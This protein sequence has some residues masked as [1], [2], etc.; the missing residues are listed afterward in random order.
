LLGAACDGSAPQPDEDEDAPVLAVRTAALAEGR[1]IQ[2]VPSAGLTSY[3]DGT[4]LTVDPRGTVR[5]IEWQY[6]A[7]SKSTFSWLEFVIASC[8]IPVRSLYGDPSG[9]TTRRFAAGQDAGMFLTQPSGFSIPDA[10][11]V[12]GMKFDSPFNEWVTPYSNRPWVSQALLLCAGQKALEL[13]QALSSRYVVAYTP[14]VPTK[15]KWVFVGDSDQG[16]PSSWRK[17]EAMLGG[18]ARTKWFKLPAWDPTK[19]KTLFEIPAPNAEQAATWSL[20][21]LDLF[22]ESALVGAAGLD[23]YRTASPSDDLTQWVGELPDAKRLSLREVVIGH[24][25]DALTGMEDASQRAQLYVAAAT[26][27][28]TETTRDPIKDWRGRFGSRLE[29]ARVF[30]AVDPTLFETRGLIPLYRLTSNGVGNPVVVRSAITTNIEEFSAQLQKLGDSLANQ[31]VLGYVYPPYLPRPEGT[32]VLIRRTVGSFS[33]TAPASLNSGRPCV[34]TPTPT[35]P[36]A[37]NAAEQEAWS[38]AE[39]PV[40]EG[41]VPY[42]SPSPSGGTTDTLPTLGLTFSGSGTSGNNAYK[43]TVSTA[44]NKN[45]TTAPIPALFGKIVRPDEGTENFNVENPNLRGGYPVVTK[46]SVSN[47]DRIA[48]NT[49]RRLRVSP[50][51]CDATTGLCAGAV[52]ESNTL[53]LEMCKAEKATHPNLSCNSVKDYYEL[54]HF[55]AAQLNIA[56]TRVAQ[57]AAALGHVIKVDPETS[58]DGGNIKLVNGTRKDLRAVEPAYL[59][60]RTDGYARFQNNGGSSAAAIPSTLD[61]EFARRGMYQAALYVRQALV[62]TDTV[63]LP[64]VVE[65]Q[66]KLKD[67]VD[68]LNTG[69]VRV[70]M[71]PGTAKVGSVNTAVIALDVRVLESNPTK[72]KYQ[73][74][75]GEDGLECALRGAISGLTCNLS[76]FLIAEHVFDTSSAVEVQLTGAQIASA[77]L[78]NPASTRNRVYLVKNVGA[79]GVAMAGFTLPKSI[80][81][82]GEDWRRLPLLSSAVAQAYTDTLAADPND[83]YRS[84]KFCNGLIEYDMRVKVGKGDDGRPSLAHALENARTAATRADQLATDVV[85]QGLEMDARAER[86]ADDLQDLCGVESDLVN[87]NVGEKTDDQSD[88]LSTPPDTSGLDACM[89]G[90]D[91]LTWVSVGTS[92]HC[93]WRLPGKEPCSCA[94]DSTCEAWL[95]TLKSDSTTKIFAQCPLSPVLVNGVENLTGPL[96]VGADLDDDSESNTRTQAELD[97]GCATYYGRFGSSAG[98]VTASAAKFP[99]TMQAMALTPAGNKVDQGPLG[100][101]VSEVVQNPVKPE[102]WDRAATRCELLAAL[103]KGD[104]K[105]LSEGDMRRSFQ[106]LDYDKVRDVAASIGLTIDEFGR[107][108]LT[109]QGEPWLRVGSMDPRPFANPGSRADRRTW[110]NVAEPWPVSRL[111]WKLCQTEKARTELLYCNGLNFQPWQPANNW[112]PTK[113]DNT[114][115][116]KLPKPG[117]MREALRIE[118]ALETLQHLTG[119]T[120]PRDSWEWTSDAVNFGLHKE[121][122]AVNDQVYRD[123]T[124]VNN[125]GFDPRFFAFPCSGTEDNPVCP[126]YADILYGARDDARYFATDILTQ[127]PIPPAES[128]NLI[129]DKSYEDLVQPYNWIGAAAFQAV[130]D[131]AIIDEAF[132]A[133]EFLAT[134]DLWD[135][136]KDPNHRGAHTAIEWT[137]HPPK[138]RSR[139]QKFKDAMKDFTGITGFNASILFPIPRGA[140]IA[141]TNPFLP[142]GDPNGIALDTLKRWQD[143]RGN[144]TVEEWPVTR[145]GA[146]DAFSLVCMAMDEKDGLLPLDQV[147]GVKSVDDLTKCQ[148]YFPTGGKIPTLRD[149]A[150]AAD[151]IASQVAKQVD[152]MYVPHVPNALL[153]TIKANGEELVQVLPTFAGEY[154][155]AVATLNGDIEIYRSST[156]A[157][158]RALNDLGYHVR[159]LERAMETLKNELEINEIDFFKEAAQQATNCAV[160]AASA[161]GLDPAKAAGGAA[162]AT[163]TCTNMV[164]QILASEEIKNLRAENI[165]NKELQEIDDF[166]SKI[167]GVFA[168]LEEQMVATRQAHSRIHGTIA[169]MDGIRAKAQRAKARATLAWDLGNGRVNAVN[170]VMR[171]RMNTTLFRYDEAWRQAVRYGFIARKSVEQTYGEEL[172]TMTHNMS[173]FGKSGAGQ[174][175]FEWAD[176]ICYKRGLDY[177]RIRRGQSNSGTDEDGDGKKDGESAAESVE[178]YAESYISDYVTKLEDFVESYNVDFPYTEGSDTVVVSLRDELKGVRRLDC[179]VEGPNYLFN[180]EA[181][182]GGLGM[183]VCPQDGTPCATINVTPEHEAALACTTVDCDPW[184]QGIKAAKIAPVLDSYPSDETFNVP[185]SVVEQDVYVEAGDYTVSFYEKCIPTPSPVNP[186]FVAPSAVR[187]RYVDPTVNGI[188]PAAKFAVLNPDAGNANLEGCSCAKQNKCLADEIVMRTNSKGGT[189]T[190]VRRHGLL[191]FSRPGAASIGFEIAAKNQANKKTLPYAIVSAPQLEPGFSFTRYFPTGLDGF[192]NVG[193]CEDSD[194]MNFRGLWTQNCEHYCP[195]GYGIDCQQ[196][197]PKELLPE[198]C[199][200]ELVFSISQEDI[201]RGK[202]ITEAGFAKGNFNYRIDT[203]GVN[204]VGTGVKNCASSD[205]ASACNAGQFLQY[206]VDQVGTFRT[207]NY[208]GDLV[209]APLF[210]GK[211]QMAKG[212]AAER[213]LTNPISSGDESLMSAYWRTELNERPLDGDYKIRV[214]KTEGL[215][216]QHLEDVQLVLKYQYWTRTQQQ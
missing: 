148:S 86:A 201:E 103:Y 98:A 100:L 74:I 153:P 72:G 20:L 214:Y 180:T 50:V 165:D 213:Y 73:L 107:Y 175:P 135:V 14:D 45:G 212:L 155:E 146:F 21:A 169:K 4:P 71:K 3:E 129:L 51:A 18:M 182:E 36:R 210:P 134:S 87:L 24:L 6:A 202:L 183:W 102:G 25:S 188:T 68:S 151:C 198:A 196:R 101:P 203:L 166:R 41:Y 69:Y 133:D 131:D 31:V 8:D 61:L 177:E 65:T 216:W 64:S 115:A 11:V 130:H 121:Y 185:A 75:L 17:H 37:C 5:G 104:Y 197:I 132:D 81:A 26:S 70:T 191:H 152:E 186:K 44:Q 83:S 116:D 80:P 136:L 161:S 171:A 28:D 29:A 49:L 164:V 89:A 63:S 140:V 122:S 209:G 174:A 22:R 142:P 154:A 117:G 67:Y 125:D 53:V 40:I 139:W 16:W 96:K 158:A 23:A 195:P 179:P 143:G 94:G 19:F 108:M 85:N 141:A 76:D 88:P 181:P 199:F 105:S 56:A 150:N 137:Y 112:D 93:A 55:D 149:A 184:R 114:P 43:L 39:S 32:D 156:G 163:A 205:L 208:E 124:D 97:A 90:P 123:P 190:W 160:A 207:R 162:A 127:Y 147:T 34:V 91:Q 192:A 211:I 99:A 10:P 168:R 128:P 7:S 204:F 84:Q 206:S 111:A 9:G 200:Y 57:E 194:G 12:G 58:L 77:K 1:P 159:T 95:N 38:K 173:L 120:G 176:T 66:N 157:M 60:A 27:A 189:D 167:D 126:E 144:W 46:L 59:Q 52:R 178:G 193:I 138:K 30:A 170:A 78:P 54:A 42:L 113:P 79:L 118:N 47:R 82:N 13:A 33:W 145:Q 109:L 35:P 187:V 48:E 110:K 106:W 92:A 215:Q 2:V 172:D 62:N 15:A 119:A